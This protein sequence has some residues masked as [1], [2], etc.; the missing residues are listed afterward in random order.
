M[1]TQNSSTR[2]LIV[3]GA[4]VALGLTTFVVLL[5]L[6]GA[7]GMIARLPFEGWVALMIVG[8]AGGGWFAHNQIKAF[9]GD[10]TLYS[11]RSLGAV[12][13]SQGI[14][15]AND[16]NGANPG[17]DPVAR[18]AFEAHS[19]VA[20]FPPAPT[21]GKLKVE[22]D[23]QL[24]VTQPLTAG[25]DAKTAIKFAG[26]ED[27]A[28]RTSVDVMR[29]IINHQFDH[30]VPALVNTYAGAHYDAGTTAART[31]AFQGD[32][33]SW[34]EAEYSILHLLH[35]P[36]RGTPPWVA[37]G[38]AP[39]APAPTGRPTQMPEPEGS[40]LAPRKIKFLVPRPAR[41]LVVESKDDEGSHASVVKAGR[42]NVNFPLKT[43]ADLIMRGLI[44]W[45]HGAISLVRAD[46]VA[47]HKRVDQ[48]LR[49]A[50]AIA[51]I[52]AQNG[53]SE[54]TGIET[55]RLA[56]E[57]GCGFIGSFSDEVYT[58]NS[59][60]AI[61]GLITKLGMSG[62]KT[63]EGFTIHPG[64]ADDDNRHR[65]VVLFAYGN[66]EL[67]KELPENVR[68][69]LDINPEEFFVCAAGIAGMAGAKFC[70][71][72][73]ASAEEIEDAYPAIS[74]HPAWPVFQDAIARWNDLKSDN[75]DIAYSEVSQ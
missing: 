23:D 46:G 25:N 2:R 11:H 67:V 58:V 59:S 10:R 69:A 14:G 17:V 3:A 71:F 74:T 26:T 45:S 55:R 13:V 43:R 52:A 38:D 39:N 29:D 36:N 34:P 8:L 32:V 64:D 30:S 16:V 24:K 44:H 68:S 6:P 31:L 65:R 72:V 9:R 22:T 27:V 15:T 54:G 50:V 57:L 37:K 75:S 20:S 63:L 47:A 21:T 73:E 61:T 1:T 51:E 56:R 18:K 48:K 62:V 41:S 42:L 35:S 33:L 40:K 66:P 12:T 70:L 28:I 53:T 7:L 60:H 5:A 4:L 49:A 19:A